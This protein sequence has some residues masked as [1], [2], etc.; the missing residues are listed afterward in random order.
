V[1]LRRTELLIPEGPLSP[2]FL[3]FG[4]VDTEGFPSLIP[5]LV[6]SAVVVVVAVVFVVFVVVETI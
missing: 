1:C 3:E 2:T 6:W 5:S 4:T